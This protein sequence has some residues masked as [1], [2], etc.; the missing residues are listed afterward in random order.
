MKT[1]D[2]I[3]HTFDANELKALQENEKGFFAMRVHLKDRHPETNEILRGAIQEFT[4][5]NLPH[6]FSEY[7]RLLKE[8]Y[9]ECAL[10]PSYVAGPTGI[11]ITLFMERPKKDQ[12]ID[13]K[14]LDEEV[15]ARYRANIDKQNREI[16]DRQV[17]LMLE[18]ARKKREQEAAQ[19]LADE[20]AA[21]RA[22]VR[23]L[24]GAA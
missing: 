17:N 18:Q 12:A 16:E 22:E 5:Q 4:F 15:E 19:A 9:K 20:E 8:G 1:N 24:L 13:I 14:V 21:I 3:F 7:A 6:A 11:F 23:T 10:Q 2:S